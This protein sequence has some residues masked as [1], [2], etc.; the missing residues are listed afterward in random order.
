MSIQKIKVIKID[1]SNRERIRRKPGTVYY[2]TDDNTM[3]I[4][5]ADNDAGIVM[6]ERYI[7]HLAEAGAFPQWVT[8][9]CIANRRQRLKVAYPKPYDVYPFNHDTGDI[10]P[11]RMY[12]TDNCMLFIALDKCGIPGIDREA[13][14]ICPEGMTD[15]MTEGLLPQWVMEKVDSADVGAKH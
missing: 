6:P 13:Y 7:Q 15:L 12:F 2:D 10:I 5:L 4:R 11:G 3:F 14:Q 1:N 9:L 8:N